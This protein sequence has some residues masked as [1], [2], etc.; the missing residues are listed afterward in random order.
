MNIVTNRFKTLLKQKTEK[1]PSN[2]NK[3]KKKYILSFVFYSFAN[4]L[5]FVFAT[6]FLIHHSIDFI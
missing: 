5:F 2:E 3:E 6:Y 4:F 1:S